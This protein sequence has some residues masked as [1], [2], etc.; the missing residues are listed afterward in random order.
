[1]K[2]KILL[3]LKSCDTIRALQEE[4]KKPF[5]WFKFKEKKEY[6]IAVKVINQITSQME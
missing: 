4:F 6:I 2:N 3:I 5:G 1:M